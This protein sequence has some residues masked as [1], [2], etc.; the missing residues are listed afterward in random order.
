MLWPELVELFASPAFHA[1]AMT[2]AQTPVQF[3]WLLNWQQKQF[4]DALPEALA[5]RFDAI[6]EPLIADN[7]M[8]AGSGPAFAQ[9]AA[10]FHEELARNAERLPELAALDVPV[11]VI[12]GEHDP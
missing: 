11:K 3:A 1:L 9:L 5:S 8:K 6:T 4:R 12:W 10:Q 7:F 2:I